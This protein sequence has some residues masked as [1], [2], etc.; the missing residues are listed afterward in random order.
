MEKNK[1]AIL[2]NCNLDKCL[3]PKSHSSVFISILP[4]GKFMIKRIK[5]GKAQSGNFKKLQFGEMF[6]S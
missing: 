6:F 4:K 5:D 3:F 1:G 2:R